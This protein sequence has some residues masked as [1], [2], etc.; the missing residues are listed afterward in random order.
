MDDFRQFHNRLRI[1]L[2]IDRHEAAALADAETWFNFQRDPFRWFIKASDDDAR[3]IW[4]AMM[5]RDKTIT[6]P[7]KYEILHPRE[8]W[9]EEMGSVLWYRVPVD[10]A[11]YCASRTYIEAHCEEDEEYYTHFSIIPRVMMLSPPE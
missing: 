3:S 2:N 8:K 7:S 9:T 4:D 11:P 10:E 5:K 1:L 6:T